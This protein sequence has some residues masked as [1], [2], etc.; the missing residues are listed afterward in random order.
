MKDLEIKKYYYKEGLGPVYS[1]HSFLHSFY[2]H[3]WKSLGLLTISFIYYYNLCIF[4][5]YGIILIFCILNN[6]AR[7]I[8]V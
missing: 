2:S 4:S 5:Y 1:S 3:H 6:I 7:V 8:F